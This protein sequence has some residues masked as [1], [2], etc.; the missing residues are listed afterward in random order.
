M[1]LAGL[2]L[3]L[4]V[5]L[6]WR[7]AVASERWRRQNPGKSSLREKDHYIMNLVYYNREDPRFLLTGR[8]GGVTVNFGHPMAVLFAFLILILLTLRTFN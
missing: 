6:I 2:I 5:L 7:G 1:L 4:L 8:S 3:S